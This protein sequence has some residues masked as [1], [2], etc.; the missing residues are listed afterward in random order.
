MLLTLQIRFSIFNF[1]TLVK[2]MKIRCFLFLLLILSINAQAQIDNTTTTKSPENNSNFTGRSQAKPV[3]NVVGLQ[4]ATSDPI[5]GASYERLFSSKVGAEVSIGLIGVSLGPKLYFPS[6][7]SGKVNFHTGAIVGWGWFAEGAY[8]Y[9]PIGIS[10]LTKHNFL[11]S[12]DVGPHTGNV[13]TNS[14]IGP[15]ARLRVGKAF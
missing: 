6:V 8:G 15:G 1:S 7:H 14:E 11:L 4:A 2:K 3:K 5:F 12:F 13:Y 9:L 10:R